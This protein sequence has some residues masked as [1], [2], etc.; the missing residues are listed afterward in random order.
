MGACVQ[1][2]PPQEGGICTFS[3]TTS[4]ASLFSLEGLATGR[5]RCWG[6]RGWIP[7][8]AEQ[9]PSRRGRQGE[10]EPSPLLAVSGEEVLCTGRA[11]GIEAGEKGLAT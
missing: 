9:G 11:G 1:L 3:L 8:G 6:A 5:D 4:G 2:R 10:K 7:V